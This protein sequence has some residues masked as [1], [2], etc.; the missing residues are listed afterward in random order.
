M[1]YLSTSGNYFE[2]KRHLPQSTKATSRQSITSDRI[3]SNI[4]SFNQPTALIDN[5]TMEVSSEFATT[6]NQSIFKMS[7]ENSVL[8]SHIPLEYLLT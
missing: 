2:M 5:H 6:F 3:T 1:S 7:I 4:L 8:K